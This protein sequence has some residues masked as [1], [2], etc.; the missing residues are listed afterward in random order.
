MTIGIKTGS[1]LNIV[2]TPDFLFSFFSSI[3][4]LLEDGR[5][6]SKFPII[7]SDLYAGKIAANKVHLAISEVTKIKELLENFPPSAVVWD[8]ED[9]TKRPP[10]GDKI[11]KSITSMANYFVTSTG[12]DFIG[13][14][15]ESLD[16]AKKKNIDVTVESA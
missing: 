4:C 11:N 7:S 5:P 6:G 10:W 1:I 9:L 14:L 13:M 2:G 15:L 8:M 16:Y 12:R 3:A